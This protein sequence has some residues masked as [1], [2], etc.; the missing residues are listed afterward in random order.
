ML[1]NNTIIDSEEDVSG[2]LGLCSILVRDQ[3]DTSIGGNARSRAPVDMQELAEEQGWLARMVHLFQSD[4][5]AVQFKV[6]DTELLR[7]V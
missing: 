7:W 4:D 1:K 6:S 5:L 2:V 3:K